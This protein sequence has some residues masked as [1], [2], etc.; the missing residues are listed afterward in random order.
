[1]RFVHGGSILK[2]YNYYYT[3]DDGGFESD[4]NLITQYQYYG[5]A[6]INPG[7]GLTFAL[8]GQYVYYYSPAI[9]YRGR[10][11]GYTVSLPEDQQ[12]VY[13]GNFSAY[14]DLWL[15]KIGAGA[16]ISNMNFYH[17]FQQNL[18]LVF[19][20]LGNLNL[21]SSTGFYHVLET[22]GDTSVKRNFLIETIG[23]RITDNFW[24]EAE[25]LSGNLKNTSLA[26]G[27]YIYNGNESITGKYSLNFIILVN[28]LTFILSGS[29]LDYYST[30]TDINNYDT[31]LNRINFH[32]ITL[33]AGLK[34]KL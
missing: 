32:G 28:K 27:L 24:L 7:L 11:T 26:D 4:E 6:V 8:S 9:T 21:Y 16:G 29:Y 33:I 31:G 10:G 19:Y 15:F 18:S 17:Q 3:P 1:L 20:P 12:N 2:K 22:K 5:S 30:F 14:K 25:V 13:A 34:W 23:T